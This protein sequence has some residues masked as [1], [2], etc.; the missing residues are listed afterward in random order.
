M[1]AAMMT[2]EQRKPAGHVATDAREIWA[3]PWAVVEM[4]KKESREHPFDDGAGRKRGKLI[5]PNLLVGWISTEEG[6]NKAVSVYRCPSSSWLRKTSLSSTASASWTTLDDRLGVK[7]RPR[8][9][10]RHREFDHELVLP[11]NPS[12]ALA[13]RRR[14]RPLPHLNPFRRRTT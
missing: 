8:E 1:Y 14:T 4:R 2:V 7:R 5:G 10:R 11:T 3:A 13:A 9:G 6:L 12:R